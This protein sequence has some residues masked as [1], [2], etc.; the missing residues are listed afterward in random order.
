MVI[1]GGFGSI[2]GS[3]FGA[4]FIV[5]VP[6]VLTNVPHLLGISLAVDTAA[7]IEPHGVWR[8]DRVFPDR[9]TAWHGQTLEYRKREI[10]YVAIPSLGIRWLRRSYRSGI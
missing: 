9:R 5:L 10:A 4:A 7:H 1:I 8:L 3:F 2:L 6:V